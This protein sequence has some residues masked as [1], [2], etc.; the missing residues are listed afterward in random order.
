MLHGIDPIFA[1]SGLAVGLLVGITGVGGGSLM[2]PLLVLVFGVHPATAVGTD[3]L[4][5]GVTK[6]SGGAVHAYHG[7]VDWR[8]TRR[9]AY[10]SV[11]AALVS[12]RA[13]RASGRRLPRRAGE[14]SARRSESR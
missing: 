12:L 1:V 13:A 6:I 4:Y 5:A 14:S 10:G 8:I 9:L 2:T 3:L 7:S 11:P